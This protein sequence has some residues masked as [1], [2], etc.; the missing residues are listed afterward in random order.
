MLIFFRFLQGIGFGAVLIATRATVSD[1]FSGTA[2]ARQM[3]TTTMLLPLIL[4]IAP[5][6][7]GV[8]QQFFQWQAVF[9]FLICYMGLILIWVQNRTETLPRPST[10][11]VSQIF[12]AYRSHLK[13]RLYW[14]YGLNLVLP[15][16][17]IFAYFTTSPFLFQQKI[18]LTPIQYGTLALYIGGAIMITGYINLKLIHRFPLTKI[19]FGGAIFLTFSGILLLIFSLLGILT[20]WSLLIPCLFFFTCYPI[21]GSNGAAKSLSFIHHDYGAA[22]AML[23]TLQFLVGALGSFIF[24]LIPDETPISLAI[25][26]ICVGILSLMTLIIAENL[27]QN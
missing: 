3:S 17:G 16:F 1:L 20:T 12:S 23:T 11:K 2:L 25:C 26:F 15:T 8:L 13:N 21:C 14:I 4:A 22:S 6:L 7:G 18:G 24:S 9:V 10:K 27:E 19:L 5:T